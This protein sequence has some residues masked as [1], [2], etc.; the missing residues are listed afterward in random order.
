MG[1][2]N[3]E[4]VKASMERLLEAE[5]EKGYGFHTGQKDL[6]WIPKSQVT[7]VCIHEVGEIEVKELKKGDFVNWIEIPFWLMESN[8][9]SDWEDQ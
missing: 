3:N 9:L 6:L 5:S 7:E 2:P 4:K 1:S 8:D